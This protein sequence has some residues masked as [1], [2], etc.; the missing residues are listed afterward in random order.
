MPFRVVFFETV[1]NNPFD[2]KI[3][4][5]QSYSFSRDIIDIQKIYGL[6][7]KKMSKKDLHDS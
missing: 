6:I 3:F 1:Y 5:K 4:S 2:N 7:E